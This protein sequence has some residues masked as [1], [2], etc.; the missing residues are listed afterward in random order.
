[1]PE[2]GA[3]SIYSYENLPSKHHKK[4]V[5][6]SRFIQ[7]VRAK[8]PK[9]TYYSS[10]GKCDLMENLENFEIT[11]YDGEKIV[12][13]SENSVN[14]FDSDGNTL[15]INNENESVRA[16]WSHYQQCFEHCKTLEKTLNSINS[17]GECFP[18]IV[19]RRP[20]SAPIVGVSKCN[21]LITPRGVSLNR[22]SL[23]RLKF[24]NR[25]QNPK[26]NINPFAIFRHLR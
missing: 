8:T 22:I 2:A 11:F 3:D 9:I 23:L 14:I 10:K 12:R 24:Q 4:Y 5:Y 1:M 18:I 19:G 6:A 21:N 20:N 25:I 16:L 13:T 17:K 26:T 7:L 15:A